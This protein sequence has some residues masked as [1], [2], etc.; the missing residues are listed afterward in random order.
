MKD[1]NTRGIGDY[2][3]R[4]GMWVPKSGAARPVAPKPGVQRP[5]AQP[6]SRQGS[7]PREVDAAIAE[8][9][10]R[11]PEREAQRLEQ[12]LRQAQQPARPPTSIS[13]GLYPQPHSSGPW[14]AW[15]LLVLVALAGLAAYLFGGGTARLVLVVAVPFLLIFAAVLTVQ[16]LAGGG[17]EHQNA[18]DIRSHLTDPKTDEDSGRY[19]APD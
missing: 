16:W 2:T 14:R 10:A 11:L 6:S 7:D 3:F 9:L 1:R 5:R 18:D 8:A 15:L 13:G 17:Q 12:M 4:N 19:W